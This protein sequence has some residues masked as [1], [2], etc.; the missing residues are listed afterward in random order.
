MTGYFLGYG[1]IEYKHEEDFVSAFY[2]THR[3]YVDGAQIL[4]D[5]MRNKTMPGWVPRRFGGGIGGKKQSGQ[6]RFG[7]RDCPFRALYTSINRN[8]GPGNENAKAGY[9]GNRN[10]M[11]DQGDKERGG[12]RREGVNERDRREGVNERDRR[13]GVNERDRRENVRE[14]GRRENG[15][16][17]KREDGNE[18]DK[19]DHSRKYNDDHQHDRDDNRRHEQSHS[20][21]RSRDPSHSRH[22]SRERSRSRHHRERSRSH[23]RSHRHCGCLLKKK[24]AQTGDRTPDL[25]VISTTL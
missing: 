23:H 14:Y 4:V 18:R 7:G 13:E 11:R 8:R 2:S 10:S 19:R 3:Q 9:G 22:H 17:R 24:N 16:E 12:Y 5:F 1:F 21:Y 6:M 15:D 25:R 20:R